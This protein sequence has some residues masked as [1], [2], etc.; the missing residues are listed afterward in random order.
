M[1]ITSR[2]FFIVSTIIILSFGFVNYKYII[3]CD[4]VGKLIGLFITAI[5]CSDIIAAKPCKLKS[6][7]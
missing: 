5:Y 4:I 7:S 3:C 6:K 1:L 2:V